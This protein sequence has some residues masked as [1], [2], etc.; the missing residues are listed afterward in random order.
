MNEKDRHRNTSYFKENPGMQFA[1]AA[2]VAGVTNVILNNK[3]SGIPVDPKQDH[4]NRM[5]RKMERLCK[6]LKI[7]W[8]IATPVRTDKPGDIIAIFSKVN[9]AKLQAEASGERAITTCPHCQ[10]SNLRYDLFYLSCKSC[11]K[12]IALRLQPGLSVFYPSHEEPVG[13]PVFRQRKKEYLYTLYEAVFDYVSEAFGFT[14]DDL[15]RIVQRDFDKNAQKQENEPRFCA[16]CNRPIPE[17]S[18][19]GNRCVYCG[20]SNGESSFERFL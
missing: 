20:K 17:T 5:N 9:A 2:V 15:T 10:T 14:W 3:S 19:I 7:L 8:T 12:E 6:S 4:L 16:H 13:E 11:D 18:Q 1:A